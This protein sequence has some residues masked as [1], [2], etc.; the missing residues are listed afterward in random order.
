MVS[1]IERARLDEA[2]QRS[3]LGASHARRHLA[4]LVAASAVLGDIPLPPGVTY[5]S[6]SD[7]VRIT[8]L[9]Y[10]PAHVERG[11][12]V[13]ARVVCTSNA[14]AVT[15]KVGS[16]VV[17]LPK[18]APGIFRA[19]LHVPLLPFYSSHQ[20]VIITAIRTDG[21]TTHKTLS[22]DVR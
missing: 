3:R 15:A 14:A 12:T 11:G 19:R 7:P 5:A 20:S 2:E 9:T 1:T 18:Q 4:L 22:V 10:W 6:N 17:N 21:A 16:V 13:V 8:S